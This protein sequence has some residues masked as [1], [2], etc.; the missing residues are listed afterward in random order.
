MDYAKVGRYGVVHVLVEEG[1]GVEGVEGDAVG[2]IEK[3]VVSGGFLGGRD[4]EGGGVTGGGEWGRRCEGRMGIYNFNESSCDFLGIISS[5]WGARPGYVSVI[6]VRMA[7][8]TEDLT[9]LLAPG[10][11]L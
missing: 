6:L 5:I 9:L 1:V 2:S 3:G 11:M 4:E 10:E 7:R 8:C